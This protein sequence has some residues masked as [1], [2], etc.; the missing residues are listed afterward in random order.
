MLD[1]DPGEFTI[2]NSVWQLPCQCAVCHQLMYPALGPDARLVACHACGVLYAP[3][4]VAMFAARERATARR[5]AL[6]AQRI[7]HLTPC[8]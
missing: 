8:A 4:L 6:A 2:I 5:D 7:A 1:V 3:E